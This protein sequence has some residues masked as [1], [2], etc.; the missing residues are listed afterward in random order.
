MEVLFVFANI[1]LV[2]CLLGGGI[3][4]G[5]LVVGKTII[6]RLVVGKTISGRLVPLVACL[7]LVLSCF[8]ASHLSTVWS[9]LLGAVFAVRQGCMMNLRVLLPTRMMM[10]LLLKCSEARLT[11]C[12]LVSMTW[13]WSFSPVML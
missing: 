13:V 6:G 3:I 4:S 7:P 5:G 1:A 12:A 2:E 8:G 10:H 9:L 11:D